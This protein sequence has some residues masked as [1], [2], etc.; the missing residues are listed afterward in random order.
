MGK[1][2]PGTLLEFERWFRSEEACREFVAKLRWP[3]GFR[4]PRCGHDKAWRTRRSLYHCS[5]CKRD[6]S[7]TAGTIFQDSRLPLRVW[8]RAAWAI[9]NQKTGVN[10]L[11]LQRLIGLGSYRTAWSCLHKFRR[12]MTR[13]GRDLLSGS[14]EIDETYVG[15]VVHGTPSRRRGKICVLVA[16]EIRGTG[17][18]RIRLQKIADDSTISIKTGIREVVAPGSLLVTDGSHAYKAL[19]PHGYSH[20]RTV[21]DGK[22]RQASSAVLPRVHRIAS[23]LKRWLLGTYQGR[24]SGQQIDHYLDE[25]T[26]RFN[27]RHSQQRGM[28]FYR[29]I[30]QSV[31]TPPRPYKKL[32]A[33]AS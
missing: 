27:R 7:V 23:L 5:H 25:Y 19:V 12:A 4:C 10:A 14:V 29:L 1:Q 18:G 28:L 15:G 21:L 22:G 20:N 33:A 16:A 9:T 3:E 2:Y 32:M 26:F 31:T 8:F 30:Q 24:V 6:I 13:S 17:I 11:G